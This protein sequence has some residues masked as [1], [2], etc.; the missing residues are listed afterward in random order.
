MPLREGAAGGAP[1]AALLFLLL[2]VACLCAP[3]FSVVFGLMVLFRLAKVPQPWFGAAMQLLAQML[4]SP[5]FFRE[6]KSPAVLTAWAKAQPAN[7]S[8]WPSKGK[9]M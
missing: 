1:L 7:I 8:Q 2:C 4:L 3:F 6:W 5:R 9:Y